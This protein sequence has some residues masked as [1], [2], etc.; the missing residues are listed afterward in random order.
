MQKAH[1]A[2][3]NNWWRN[4]PD[5]TT[6]ITQDELNR[7]ETTV[8]TI[9]DRVVLFDTTKANQTDLLQTIKTITYNTETGIWVFTWWNGSILTIDQNIEKIPVSFSMSPQ[10]VITMTTSD[11]TQYTCDI[12]ALIKTYSFLDSDTIDFTDTVDS[13]GNHTITA[14]IKNGSITGDKLQPN[15]L[16][17]CVSAK[18]SAETAETNAETAEDNALAHQYTAE[19]W[20][21]GTKNGVPVTPSDIQYH[22]SAEY[23]A[24]QARAIVGD[25]VESF[26]GRTGTVVAEDGD[27]ES[28][29]IVPATNAIVGQVP[30]V[31]NVGTGQEVKLRYV[32]EDLDIGLKPHIIVI[33]EANSTVRLVKG[34]TTIYATETT[35]EHFECDVTEFGVWTVHSVLNGEDA[36]VNLTVDAVKI[37]TVDDSHFHS[38][39]TVTYPNGATCALS[40]SGQTTRY[41]TGSP[42]TFT[43]HYAGTYTITVGY[44]G[45]DYTDTV[46][47]TATGQTFAKTV[48]SP[49]NAPANDL[50]LW[51]WYGGVSGTY[52]TLAD[53]LAD[54]TALSTLM[55]STDAVDY[56]VRCTSW[57]SDIT[58]NQSAMSYIGLNNYCA[59]TLL[60]DST[61]STAICNSTYFESVLNVKVPTMTSNT[62]PSGVCFGTNKSSDTDY[63]HAFNGDTT[64]T[65]KVKPTVGTTSMTVGYEFVNEVKAEKANIVWDIYRHNTSITVKLQEYYNN[66]WIDITSDIS[67]EG[68]SGDHYMLT[69]D[70]P[71]SANYKS[72]KYRAYI[73]G[74]LSPS[75]TSF[76]A[77]SALQFYGREDI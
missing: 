31:R 25:K 69:M 5:I 66:E 54:S 33:S 30:V 72:N 71:C 6:P 27:Y 70:I 26:N 36:Q 3:K 51:L 77:V 41:A 1:D 7:L 63:Y 46:E 56:L 52:S 32:N 74:N 11:G 40:A 35:T 62:T 61:W 9:D 73:S 19:A 34:T 76:H 2:S 17:D 49:A 50:D 57:V 23:W 4:L 12:A 60:A 47:V 20:A 39:I 67:V 55:A 18:E 22:N 59:N 75:T 24:G 44:D 65:S 38:D 13:D 14:D 37:Y 45:N 15:Y 48:P 42:Y 16:A 28:D 58:G 10:G 29:M 21:K 68:N 8:D 43:V 64:A 53:V